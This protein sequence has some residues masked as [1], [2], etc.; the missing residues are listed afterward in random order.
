[1]T[2]NPLGSILLQEQR[3]ISCE[4]LRLMIQYA[5]LLKPSMSNCKQ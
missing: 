2:I 5:W 3:P 4:L 1:M